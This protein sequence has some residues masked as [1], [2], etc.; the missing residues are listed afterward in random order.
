MPGGIYERSLQSVGLEPVLSVEQIES[1]LIEAANRHH[2]EE[3]N[4]AYWLLEIDRRQLYRTRGF[5]SLGD[6]A[7]ELV[8]IKPRKAWYLVFIAERLENLPAIRAEFDA[9]KLSWTKAREIVAVATPDTE[10]EWLAKA[11]V[12]SNRDLEKEVRRHDGRGSGAFAT[13]TISMPVEVLEMWHDTY[14]L[15]ERL[16]GTELEK[17]QVLEASLAELL[18]THLPLANE[19]GASTQETEDEKGLA[20]SVRNAVLDRDGWACRFPACTMRKMLDVH[21]IEFRSHLGSDEMGN[22]IS[23]CRIHHGLIHRGICSMSGTV[24]VDLK[25]ERPRL[26]NQPEHEP[27]ESLVVDDANEEVSHEVVNGP[28]DDDNDNDNIHGDD[29]DDESWRDEVIA[30]IFNR[31]PS[32]KPPKPEGGF[33]DWLTGWCDRQEA[34]K[35][36]ARSWNRRARRY[37]EPGSSAHV[38]TEEVSTDP[39]AE[40]LETS[41]PKPSGGSPGG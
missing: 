38:C 23:L 30:D 37:P 5:S 41:D 22:L 4:I 36:E 6:Y 33:A 12:L 34:S 18:G 26:V 8:G 3:R 11:R 35:L 10:E 32:P 20:A 13:V 19:N 2:L 7:M 21:H 1:H 9:G 25:F 24:G 15:V 27:T 40:H 31:P 28:D 29:D 17:W 16:S 39:Q 14:E